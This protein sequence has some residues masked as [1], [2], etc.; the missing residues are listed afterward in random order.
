MIPLTVSVGG[1]TPPQGGTH[2]SRNFDHKED[3]LLLEMVKK[4]GTDSWPSVAAAFMG[5]RN[6]R[7]CRNRYMNFLAPEL[8]KDPWTPEEDE[9]LKK[10]YEEIGPRWAVLR[11]F[12]PGRTDLN[13]KNRFGFLTRNRADV[14]ELKLKYLSEHRGEVGETDLPRRRKKDEIRYDGGRIVDINSLF[15]SLPY[16]MKRCMLLEALLQDNQIPVPPEGI[17]EEKQWLQP[18]ELMGHDDVV[19]QHE[20]LPPIPEPDEGQDK[21]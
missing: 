18:E 14:R 2:V 20:E 8:N 12:F 11:T 9:L 16:Y 21:N 3:E 15:D 19:D 13:I 10:Q 7:Q 5:T 4:Y 17:C 6:A 1:I